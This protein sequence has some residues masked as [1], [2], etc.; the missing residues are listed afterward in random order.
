MLAALT[1]CQSY[2]PAAVLVRDAETGRPI[3]GAEVRISYPP[4]RFAVCPRRVRRPSG[5]DGIAR[6]KAAPYGDGGILVNVA[7]KG[8]L[9]EHESLATDEVRG[10]SHA[11][12][13][14]DVAKRRESLAVGLLAEPRPYVELVLPSYLRGVVKVTLDIDDKARLTPGQRRFVGN[15]TPLGEAEVAGP[16]IL[17]HASPVEYRGKFPDGAPLGLPEND[18]SIGFGWLKSDGKAILLRR[19]QERIRSG[20]PPGARL[21]PDSESDPGRRTPRP[22][23]FHR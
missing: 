11:H 21:A 16:P 9:S 17:R 19:H 1:G 15:A 10:C 3:V 2:R 20:T 8:Y 12:W 13:F 6:L 7:A 4:R 18:H 14:E 23:R 5:A 22:Q